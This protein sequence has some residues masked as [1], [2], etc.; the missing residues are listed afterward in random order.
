MLEVIQ[1]GEGVGADQQHGFAVG[2]GEDG[3]VEGI[4]AVYHH[5]VFAV[6]VDIDEC[7]LF[8]QDF[9]A[10][11]QGGNHVVQVFVDVEALGIFLVNLL[12]GAVVDEGEQVVLLVDFG[13]GMVGAEVVDIPVATL[14]DEVEEDAVCLEVLD[15]HLDGGRRLGDVFDFLDFIAPVRGDVLGAQPVVVVAVDV[16]HLVAEFAGLGVEH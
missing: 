15:G 4:Q 11:I 12:V 5:L 7:I 8:E 6:E 3:I 13:A 14:K 1:R 16:A 10:N 2:K 9:V